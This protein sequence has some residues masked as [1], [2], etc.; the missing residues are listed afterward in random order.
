[1][2]GSISLLLCTCYVHEREIE[3]VYACVC[4]YNYICACVYTYDVCVQASVHKYQIISFSSCPQK[5]D[6]GGQI[7]F[8]LSSGITGIQI[9]KLIEDGGNEQPYQ[10][11]S[12][13]P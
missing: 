8:M 4:I 11:F 10:A 12:T 1:M 3:T 6:V 2:Q 7:L 5:F 13:F 9:S